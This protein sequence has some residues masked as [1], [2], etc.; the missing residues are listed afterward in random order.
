[1]AQELLSASLNFFNEKTFFALK[2]PKTNNKDTKEKEKQKKIPKMINPKKSEIK[3][4]N[5]E[6]MA[7]V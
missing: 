6:I 2:L 5:E 3:M 4:R 1:M 7:K